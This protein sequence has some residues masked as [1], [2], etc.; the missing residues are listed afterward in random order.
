PPYPRGEPSARPGRG[1]TAPLYQPWARPPNSG[2]VPSSPPQLAAAGGLPM[3]SNITIPAGQSGAPRIIV[4][5]AR[6]P[7]TRPD[8]ANLAE[9]D[10][11]EA[12]IDPATGSVQEQ[13]VRRTAPAG[14]VAT[15]C[16]SFLLNPA[17][18]T[19]TFHAGS[20]GLRYAPV[21]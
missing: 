13:V 20:P 16:Q 15:S 18:G 9:I 3:G 14:G 17:R 19:A 6:D 8:V 11:V 2:A 12:W 21:R 5:A 1:I 7:I 10:L 4:F